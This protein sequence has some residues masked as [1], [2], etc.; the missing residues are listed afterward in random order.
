MPIG[1][2]AILFIMSSK[3]KKPLPPCPDPDKFILV[4]S[5]EGAHWRRKRGTVNE[6]TLNTVFARNAA[7]SKVASPAAKRMVQKLRP[8]IQE[9]NTGRLTAKLAGALIQAINEHGEPDF[10]FMDLL[11]IHDPS[12]DKLL[13]VQ[14]TVKGKKGEIKITI[15]IGPNTLYPKNKQV[16][17]YY[18]EAILLFGD[19]TKDNGLRIDSVISPLY[20]IKDSVGTT[21]ELLLQLPQTSHPWIVLLKVS[22]QELNRPSRRYEDFGMKV[23]MVG[24]G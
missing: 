11:E 21:C 20:S 16:T 18:F 17:D 15:P 19:V 24:G 13:N 4:N 23:V 5:K 22:C 2:R 9:L 3:K 6:A 10:S 12:L 7:N 8:F 1:S 14:V